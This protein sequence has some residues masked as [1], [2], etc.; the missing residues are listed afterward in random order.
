MGSIRILLLFFRGIPR[1][2]AELAAEKLA[3]R[4]AA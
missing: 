4:P 2:S 1:D 3:L